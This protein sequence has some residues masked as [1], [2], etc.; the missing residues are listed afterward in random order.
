MTSVWATQGVDGIPADRPASIIRRSGPYHG[1]LRTLMLSRLHAG[2]LHWP[3]YLSE[4]NPPREKTK[5]ARW[6]GPSSIIKGGV[7]LRGQRLIEAI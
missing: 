7:P 6:G 2:R 4:A 3:G 1:A 5:K